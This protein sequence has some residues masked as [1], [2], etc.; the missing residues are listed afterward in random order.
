M[1]GIETMNRTPE[2]ALL[3]SAT[4]QFKQ[5]YYKNN[6]RGIDKLSNRLSIASDSPAWSGKIRTNDKRTIFYTVK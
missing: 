5:A 3:D 4:A 6:S 1:R 2:Q